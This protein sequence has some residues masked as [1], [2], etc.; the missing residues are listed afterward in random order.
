MSV[1][2]RKILLALG[3]LVAFAV[4][5]LAQTTLTITCRC[6][7]GGVNDAEVQWLQNYVIPNF[8]KAMADKGTPVK[9]ALTQFGG[10]DEAL[11]QQ[12]ALDLSVHKGYDVMAFDGFWIPEFASGGL[13]KPLETV[14]GSAV[15]GWD[16]W[17]HI[18]TGIQDIMAYDGHRYGIANGTDVR[19]IFYRKDILQKAG[20]P[21]ADAWQPTSWQDILDT[22]QMVKKAMPD[23]YPL[24]IDAGTNMGEATTLQGYYMLILG[25]G[26]QP[27]MNGKW[28]VKSQGILDTLNFYK[29]I[30]VDTKVGDQRVQLVKD[31]RNQSFANFRD[32][33]TSMLVESDWFY[34]SVTKPGSEFAVANRD[35]VMGWAKMPAEKPGMGVRGQSFVTASGGTGWVLNPNTA[36]PAEAW[37]LLA[38]MN[39]KAARDDFEAYQPTI[40][41]RDD[42]PVPNNPFLTN[43]AKTLLP[44]T[45]SRPNNDAYAKVS[46]QI[47]LMTENVVSGQMSP[48]QAMDAYAAAVTQIVGADN[49]V[50][51]LKTAS[52]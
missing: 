33:V 37:D 6:V 32:G 28:V 21:N 13:L 40:S 23:S 52:N 12:Y 50:D 34:R 45:V 16:G 19:M 27:F 22:A 11:K 30:Y 7:A 36:H 17:S 31:G 39:G 15:A 3:A 46:E 8:E 10:T 24:Q 14:A 4:P 42:V 20:V 1:H 26:E 47:Q 44:L 2:P 5:A 49:T 35:Q 51:L 29:K 18:S 41:A 48:Q 38:F 9:V 43:T 25:T